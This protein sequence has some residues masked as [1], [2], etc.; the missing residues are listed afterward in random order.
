MSKLVSY[1]IVVYCDD[2]NEQMRRL[3]KRNPNLTD[4]DARQ[5]L[6]AQMST[7]ERLKRADYI[8]DN[9]KDIENTRKQIDNLHRILVKTRKHWKIRFVVLLM[10]G[11]F[12]FSSSY[13]VR[14]FFSF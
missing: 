5:R 4:R 9:S 3:L 6:N 7:S 8:I 1:K 2:E 12:F 14:Y 13:L 11:I 10:A